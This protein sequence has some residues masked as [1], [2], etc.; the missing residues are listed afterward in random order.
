MKHF[1][2]AGC[3]LAVLVVVMLAREAAGVTI[4][5]GG[6]DGWTNSANVD[7]NQWLSTY[8]MKIGDTLQFDNN[9]STDHTAVV[10]DKEAYDTCGKSG[11][12]DGPFTISPGIGYKLTWFQSGDAYVICDIPGHCIQGQKVYIQ[13]LNSDGTVNTTANQAP[14][15]S[16]APQ[17]PGFSWTSQL[18]TIVVSTF[19]LMVAATTL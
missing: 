13:V 19:S 3:T 4:V 12:M 10:V 18:I 7:Y 6:L 9:D 11:Q 15:K 14:G 8:K 2:S 1:K 16:A 17:M 5:L